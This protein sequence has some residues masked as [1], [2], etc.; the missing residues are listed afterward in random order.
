M[1]CVFGHNQGISGRG[2]ERK[3]ERDQRGGR[4]Y[5]VESFTNKIRWRSLG[6]PARDFSL[7]AASLV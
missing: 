4:G 1:R 2:K 7:M 3:E 5:S 6:S